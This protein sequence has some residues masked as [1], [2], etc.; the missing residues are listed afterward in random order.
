VAEATQVVEETPQNTV[1]DEVHR[2]H[3]RAAE[4]MQLNDI[5]NLLSLRFFDLNLLHDYDPTEKAL[6][7]RI[8]DNYL[9]QVR[10]S[11]QIQYE[12]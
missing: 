12:K 10:S 8:N 9:V 3:P 2:H 1:H 5:A 6:T 4:G 7:F 11:E